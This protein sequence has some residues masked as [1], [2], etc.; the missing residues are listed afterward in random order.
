MSTLKRAACLQGAGFGYFIGPKL[1]VG[2]TPRPVLGPATKAV[3]TAEVG[4]FAHRHTVLTKLHHFRLGFVS[5]PVLMA[6]VF[7]VAGMV[8]APIALLGNDVVRTFRTH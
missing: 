4:S 2:T 6:C 7:G 3:V 5:R 8:A 1:Y